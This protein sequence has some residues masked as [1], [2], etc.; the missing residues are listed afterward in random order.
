MCAF[1]LE[2]LVAT[3]WQYCSAKTFKQLGKSSLNK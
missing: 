1:E 2:T 3:R